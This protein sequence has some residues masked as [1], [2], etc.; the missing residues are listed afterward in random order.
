MF[1]AWLFFSLLSTSTSTCN[2]F[3][4][5][6]SYNIPPTQTGKT[7]STISPKTRHIGQFI[8]HNEARE[9]CSECNRPPTQCL[10]D[11]LPTTKISLETQVLV[12]QHPVEFRRKTVSTVPVLKLVLKNCQ[13]M[14]G[15][16]F[17][18]QLE[19]FIDNAC[20]EGRIPLLLFP[21]P[22]AI[23]LEDSDAMEQLGY[24]HYGK[25]F[26]ERN[27]NGVE[28][29]KYLLIIVDGTW[30]QAKRMLRYSP[31]LLD[32]CHTIQFTG[33]TDRSIYDSIRKQPDFFC[34]STLESCAR[35]LKLLEPDNPFMKKAKYHLEES[36]K[37]LVLTQMKHEQKHLE[38]Y[39]DSIR[40]VSKIEAKRKRQHQTSKAQSKVVV[41][42]G[43]KNVIN[44]PKN[45]FS[46]DVIADLHDGYELRGLEG[47]SDAE[48][49]NSRWPYQSKKSLK[50]IERQINADNV[51]ATRTGFSTCL[52]IEYSGELVA[53]IL[54]HRNGSLGILHVDDEHR[55]LG[56]GEILLNQATVALKR[57][58][59][60][61]FAFIVDGN[62]A[63]EAL[64][65]KLGW[66]KADPFA[67][68]GTG[69]RKAKRMWNYN[70]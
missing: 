31:V 13:V 8:E 15:R 41:G 56:L 29:S 46:S 43:E 44:T 37:A 1:A 48:Y 33:T 52:G 24:A 42:S 47:L 65:T 45:K 7:S 20:Y 12:L 59:E 57:R 25:D 35:T 36:L 61:V 54:R 9:Y 63:S 34:L 69:K 11:Y 28:K 62:N 66:V 27:G 40:N 5:T 3:S 22:N 70:G 2:A 17:D 16:S 68:K 50:M 67:K 51:N 4:A 30:T 21:G 58:D 38:E 10:C 19:S 18:V 64:F 23:T 49:V 53:C 32:K 6:S 55:R 60:P 14:V 26:D 39:P